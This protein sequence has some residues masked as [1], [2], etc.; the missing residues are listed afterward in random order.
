MQP[1]SSP[2][3]PDDLV[4]KLEKLNELR[5]AGLLTEEEF[6]AQKVRLLSRV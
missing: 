5:I 3:S 4:A 2:L 6:S 1:P